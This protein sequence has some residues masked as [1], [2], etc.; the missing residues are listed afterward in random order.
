M[1][2]DIPIS[3]QR[4]RAL[5]RQFTAFGDP[6]RQQLFFLIVSKKLT[7][8]ELA[9]TLGIPR[10]TV[11]HHLKILRDAGL[12]KDVQDGIRR[13]YY[14]TLRSVIRDMKALISSVEAL[15]ERFHLDDEES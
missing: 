15:R 5:G 11:S 7:V 8:Q 2:K 1:N 14:P 10:P 6:T 12:I 13:Y 4:F 9:D 3:G